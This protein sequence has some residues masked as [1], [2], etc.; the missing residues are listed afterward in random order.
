MLIGLYRAAMSLFFLA[1][2]M[3]LTATRFSI[4]DEGMH[5][6][7]EIGKLDL[8]SKGLKLTPAEVFSADQTSLVDGIVR[9]NGCTGSFV[10]NQGLII[11]NHHCAYAAI[12]Q[13]STTEHDYLRQGFVAASLDKELPAIGY[14]VRVTESFEDVSDQMLAAV[15]D[16]MDFVERTK[17][18]ERRQKELEKIG[19]ESH[20]G[21]RA[22]VAEMFSGK[23]YVRFHYTFI[24]DVR[25]VFA[26]PESVG[27]FGGDVDNWEW[28]RHTGDFSFMRAYVAP[29][30]RP[31]DYSPSN[32]PYQPKRFIQVASRGPQ[33]GDFVMLLG[34]PGRTA[35]HKTARYLQYLQQHVLPS[36][37]ELNGQLM[38]LMDDIG[39]TDRA[40]ALKNL[41]RYQSLANVEKR[42]R[43]QL[44]GLANT[45][46]LARRID[47]EKRLQEHIA[48]DPTRKRKSGHLI[49][50]ISESYDQIASQHDS[51]FNFAAL[52]AHVL[53]YSIAATLYESAQ[54]RAKPDLEREAPYMDRNFDLTIQGIWINQQN[55]NPPT[56][57]RALELILN[58]A[59]LDETK[60]G[61]IDSAQLYSKTEI[62]ERRFVEE[63]LKKTPTEL[64]Q[65]GD[66]F[67]QMAV[68]LYPE[69]LRLRELN[70]SRDGELNKLYGEL[71]TIK[72][73]FLKT[74]FV[75]DANGTLRLTYGTIRGYSPAD[76][77]QMQP[78]TTLNGMLVKATGEEPF[79]APEA[80]KQASQSKPSKL[81]SL[82]GSN[83]I[84]VA[85]LY[86]TDTTGGNSGSPVINARGELV[87][88]N[89]DRT[90]EATINDF[91][92]NTNYSRSIGVDIRYALWITGVVFHGSHL[93]R[94]MNISLDE[95]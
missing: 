36:T 33:E 66:P 58:R 16:S 63:C 40:I 20:P 55:F 23:T 24:K 60:F 74:S 47:E 7:S 31:A 4:A 1:I 83:E 84:P 11:T 70:K 92:W 89:F 51:E 18:L 65:L 77:V 39:R 79:I 48:A 95:Q 73:E 14:T 80:L 38:K 34:Y 94:E 46:I 54:E 26:P 61:R 93:L 87:G 75:P 3:Q 13:S 21:M 9:V 68:R 44:K 81:F 25:L 53:A 59:R 52:R 43:G 15:N 72:Q 22:E 10:S 50:S 37:V 28:P 19:E 76:A 88:V 45:P 71:I 12:Q 69:Q 49:D 41:S 56:D 35:R 32:I 8:S 30:G 67:I 85:M 78:F 91:A 6:I 64:E 57:R 29:D 82:P 62:A 90:F 5:P 27:K 17:A 86:D 42:S 2:G